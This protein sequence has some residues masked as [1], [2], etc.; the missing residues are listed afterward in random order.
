V[1]SGRVTHGWSGSVAEFLSTPGPAVESRLEQHLQGLLGHGAALS[2]S[3]AWREEVALMRAGLRDLVISRADAVNWSVIFEYELPL[4]GGRRPDVIILGSDELFVL[5]FKQDSRAQRSA[6]DQVAAYARDLEEYQSETHGR[7]AHALL[8]PTKSS[9]INLDI[10]NVRVISPNRLASALDDTRTGAPIQLDEWL[11]GEYRPLPTLIAAARMIFNSERLPAIKRHESLGVGNAVKALAEIAE[12]AETHGH[13]NLAFISGVPG[14]GKTLVGLQFVYEQSH[15]DAS[16]VFL[17][18]N[19]PL[20]EVLRDALKSKAFVRDLHSFITGYGQTKKIPPHNVIVFD[21]AQRAWDSDYMAFKKKG[22][23]S[24]PELLIEIG[25]R[26]PRWATLVGLVGHGQEINSGEEAGMLGW[27]SALDEA[28]S[29]S[30]WSVFVPPRFS[31]EFSIEQV[32]E[33]AELDLTASLRSRQA[34]TLHEWVAQLLDGKLSSA[35]RLADRMRLQNFPI[36][37]TRELD[38]AKGHITN[39]YQDAPE[40]RFGLLASSKDKSLPAFGIRNSFQD[41]KIIKIAPWYNSP[42]GEPNSG[43]NLDSVV[44]E[45][46]CQGLELDMALVAWGDDFLWDGTQ[47]QERKARTQFPQKDQHQIRLN[48]YRVLLTRS[49]DGILIYLPQLPTFD[50]TEHALLAGG[51]RVLPEPISAASGY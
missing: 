13:R 17:S 1:D 9:D 33:V 3:E 49:R 12:D 50:L 23:K 4:E 48:S 39:L 32:V 27:S 16:A 30:E 22:A 35:A 38:Q 41:T 7:R 2:Q 5:E 18:G 40:A 10:D 45:F 11:D 43:S 29:K 20:V 47:W 46:G 8:V 37:L 51:V 14:A 31:A 6:I 28:A 36:F 26:I 15:G 44:T 34:E 24:E 42:R 21:E 25:S 19:G